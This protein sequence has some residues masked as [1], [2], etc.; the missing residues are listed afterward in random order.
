M[1]LI[2]DVFINITIYYCT[3]LRYS[4]RSKNKGFYFLCIC[5]SCPSLTASSEFRTGKSTSIMH[6]LGG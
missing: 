5:T 4:A 3:K 6:T 2:I 1:E